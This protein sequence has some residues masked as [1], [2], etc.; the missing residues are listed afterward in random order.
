MRNQDDS[1]EQVGQSVHV[2]KNMSH[3]IGDELDEQAV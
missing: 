3:R 1:L 2:L